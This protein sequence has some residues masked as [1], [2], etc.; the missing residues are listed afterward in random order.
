MSYVSMLLAEKQF[1]KCILC[2]YLCIEVKKKKKN[3]VRNFGPE[4]ITE[5]KILFV[6]T[7]TRCGI[8]I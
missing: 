1:S 2:E 6:G 7:R 8:L 5:L 3:V 4:K